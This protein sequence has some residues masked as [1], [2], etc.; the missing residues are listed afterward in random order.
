[1]NINSSLDKREFIGMKPKIRQIRL[2]KGLM[3]NYCAEKAGI[4]QQ[5]WSAYEKGT[6]Y[7]RIDRAYDIA[8]VLGVDVNELY[9]EELGE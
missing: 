9:E 2:S 8:N 3:Q 4:S 7:P 5:L 1:M 6:K